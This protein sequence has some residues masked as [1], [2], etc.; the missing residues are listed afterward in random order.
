LQVSAFSSAVPPVSVANVVV[1]PG[2]STLVDT[3]VL[4]MFDE[5]DYS[6][7]LYSRIVHLVTPRQAQ[8]SPIP[9]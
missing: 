6:Q 8:M 9:L 3:M 7:W 4:Q 5:E 1:D 2:F